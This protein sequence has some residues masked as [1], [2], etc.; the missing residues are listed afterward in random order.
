MSQEPHFVRYPRM[1]LKL[2]E[3]NLHRVAEACRI[4]SIGSLGSVSLYVAYIAEG[5]K[6]DFW[7]TGYVVL[8]LLF[9]GL[10][11]RLAGTASAATGNRLAAE[12]CLVGLLAVYVPIVYVAQF[13]R[14]AKILQQYGIRTGVLGPSR[15]EVSEAIR[16]V[17]EQ[18]SLR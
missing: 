17:A 7:L 18:Q 1:H 10:A 15:R 8:Y 3:V 4:A 14:F 6:N 13:C 16:D 2:P 9:V 5:A 12:L 11:V